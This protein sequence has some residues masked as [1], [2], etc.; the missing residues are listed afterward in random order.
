M[1][2]WPRLSETLT[3]PIE[4][5]KCRSCGDINPDDLWQE[6]DDAD[7]PEKIYILLCKPCA[8]KLIK[9]HPRLYIDLQRNQPIPG[10][11]PICDNCVYREGYK[12]SQTLAAGGPGLRVQISAP[13][14]CHVYYGGGRGEW[15]KLWS[16]TAHGCT[17]RKADMSHKDYGP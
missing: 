3:G 12:C 14:V 6:C 10:M 9:P 8:K 16:M 5:Q 11:M 1:S 15:L 2:K 17:Q 7:Q 4:T 13:S